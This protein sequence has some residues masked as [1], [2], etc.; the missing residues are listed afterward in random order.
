MSAA[1]QQINQLEE[2]IEELEEI[3]YRLTKKEEP[4]DI[5][6][7]LLTPR[8]IAKKIMIN[9]A[10]VIPTL[11]G[12]GILPAEDMEKSIHMVVYGKYLVGDDGI[13]IDN[14]IKYPECVDKNRAIG[15]DHP[16]FKEKIKNMKKQIRNSI[17]Q[18]SIKKNQLK[19][20]FK[21]AGQQIITGTAALVASATVLPIGAG[22]PASI[23]AVQTIVSAITDLQYKVLEILP[24]LGPLIEIP[25]I[26]MDA[27][28]AIVLAAINLVLTALII[29][30]GSIA[31][32]KELIA[33]LIL[34]IGA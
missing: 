6:E 12:E 11:D 23:A 34:A 1:Q 2:N 16:I 3:I 13:L 25:L 26:I 20:A 30:I 22:V 29:V 14:E 33:P 8:Q 10:P 5:W 18:I 24:L 17:E 9:S 28:I 21:L 31:T 4:I 15:D 32:L 19:D 7:Y 27:G